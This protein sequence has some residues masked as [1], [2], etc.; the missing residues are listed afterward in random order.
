M[1]VQP[2][3]EIEFTASTWTDV[4]SDVRSISIRRGK[5][6]ELGL[7]EAGHFEVRLANTTRDYDPT[8]ASSPHNGNLLP[9]KRLRI[10]GV[11][12]STTYP[13]AHGN[14]AG[15]PQ[16]WPG[17][18][19]NGLG[20]AEV[21][22]Y[23]FDGFKRLN[24]AK[25]A[26]T[27][28]QQLL[29]TA[30]V[31]QIA[32]GANA[33]HYPLD[34]AS[35]ATTIVDVLDS[36]S[37]TG[38]GTNVTV[39]DTDRP[40]I[41]GRVRSVAFSPADSTG[42]GIYGTGP[43]PSGVNDMVWACWAK[44]ASFSTDGYVVAISNGGL[45]LA[46]TIAASGTA[47]LKS[48]GTSGGG[49]YDG[50]LVSFWLSDG[51][52]H[53]YGIKIYSTAGSPGTL[54][55]DLYRDGSL[56]GSITT[57]PTGS[58]TISSWTSFTGL[59]IGGDGGTLGGSHG[60]DAKVG[61]V[62]VIA[63]NSPAAWPDLGSPAWDTIPAGKA[64]DQINGILDGAG[65]A[66]ADRSI[67]TGTVDMVEVSPSEGDP[68]LSLLQQIAETSERGLFFTGPDEKAYFWDAATIAALTS[69]ASFG[70]SA[71]E[72]VVYAGV[73]TRY[74]D[75]DIWNEVAIVG[76]AQTSY[77][78]DAT[79]IATYS[80]S[81]RLLTVSTNLS[82]AADADTLAATL[83]ANYKDPHNRPVQLVLASGSDD[84]TLVQIFARGPGDRVT[85][86]R[87]PPGGGSSISLDAQIEGVTL[88]F[89]PDGI[90]NCVWDLGPYL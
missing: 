29:Y 45:Y 26:G 2:K 83:L 57:T 14:I 25:V 77:V 52:W 74:D 5:N 55:G 10:T 49:S 89:S 28:F 90:W 70:D 63:N 16:M 80:G 76:G 81:G 59:Q 27:K 13:L 71:T 41:Y 3:I 78:E 88:T 53:H 23:A 20:D 85:V 39:G 68:I 48:S 7:M 12:N 44:I 40:P 15:W 50:S 73:Q 8:Y 61:Q 9:M 4:S 30:L 56:I 24:L 21:P 22:L 43:S 35:G 66:A 46:W 72:D 67:D 69:S 47:H 38:L 6:H 37:L 82:V 33:S 11:A 75:Q 31:A 84:A 36:R 1:A 60:I 32:T 19:L 51:A 34:E 79:S 64:G 18:V 87:R 17:R 58:P 62:V 42:D 54:G 65:W 86:V